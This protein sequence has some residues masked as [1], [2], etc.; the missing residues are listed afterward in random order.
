MQSLFS[1]KPAYSARATSVA[2][3]FPKERVGEGYDYCPSGV[4]TSVPASGL[5]SNLDGEIGARVWLE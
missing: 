2:F 1:L 3:P 4:V 5:N